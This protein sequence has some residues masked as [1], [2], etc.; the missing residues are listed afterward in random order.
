[1]SA[2]ASDPAHVIQRRLAL[3][4]LHNGVGIWD[5][6][7]LTQ[8]M[9]WDD[10]MFVLYHLNP[11]D[12][13]G[14]V[15]A[16]EKSLHPEDRA[17]AELDVQAALRGEKPFD[18]EFRVCW[19][20]GETHHI[21]AVATVFRDRN[22]QPIRMLGTNIDIT[23]QRIAEQ[24]LRES[25]EQLRF[26]LQGAELGFWDWNIV[27]GEVQRNAKW[28]SMLGYTHAEI[29]NT[30]KQWTEFIHPDDRDRAWQSIEAVLQGQAEIHKIEYRMLHKDGSER[31][32]LDQANVMQRN[33]HGQP[34]RMCGIHT[35]ITERK[36]LEQ[37]LIRRAHFDYLTGIYNRGHFMEL[38]E[39]ELARAV[40]YGKELAV[41]M[42]DLDNFKQINDRYGHKVG[43]AVLKKFALVCQATLRTVDILGRMGGEEFAI[44]LPETD[45]AMAAEVAERLRASIASALVPLEAGLPVR[46]TVSIGVAA[47]LSRDDNIDLLL[48]AADQALYQAK[49]SGRNKVCLVL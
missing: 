7:L 16:W 42:M 32:I 9:I 26:V 30:T 23:Q 13:S 22:G 46:F 15:D 40:R 28:A 17:Q 2:K 45:K 14:A 4:N 36:L 5:W 48:S 25:E 37:E 31:W 49:N 12:F 6:N 24:T 39:Q 38:A 11:D 34:T 8:E 35:D 27:T 20:N 47:M 3:A 18:T 21:K 44:L 33:K 41:F 43:D 29:Q 1:M 19:Q 10:S